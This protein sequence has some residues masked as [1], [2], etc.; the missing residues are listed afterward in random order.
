MSDDTVYAYQ[1]DKIT[2]EYRGETRYTNWKK[3]HSTFEDAIPQPVSATI[4]TSKG[5]VFVQSV[6]YAVSAPLSGTTRL[7][8]ST[9]ELVFQKQE[10]GQWV[11]DTSAARVDVSGQ[12]RGL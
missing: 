6:I 1:Y 4:N 10:N 11:D 12:V 8:I 7:D 2:G 5:P 9:Q 3:K